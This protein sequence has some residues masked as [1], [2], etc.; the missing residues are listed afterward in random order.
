MSDEFV[1]IANLNSNSRG[2]NVRVKVVEMGV[3]RTVFSRRDDSEHRVTEALV[4]DDTGCIQ[5]TLWDKDIEDISI[6]DVLE[7]KNGYI[8]IFRGSMKLNV[9]RYGTR[10]KID[11]DLPSVNT[12]NNLSERTV[13]RSPRG[14]FGGGSDRRSYGQGRGG[15]RRRY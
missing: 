15:S 6:D 4:G 14:R 13:S 3:P 5:L 7:I 12:E 11:E 10:E 2:V 9:G 1:K 8:N